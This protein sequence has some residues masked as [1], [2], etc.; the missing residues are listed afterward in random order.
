MNSRVPMPGGPT[1][2]RLAPAP[3]VRRDATAIAFCL[4]CAIALAPDALADTAAVPPRASAAGT[5]ALQESGSLRLTS[6]HEFTLNE[7]GRAS[8]TIKGAIYVHLRIVSTSRVSAE[9][10]IYPSHGSVTGYATASYHR[11]GPTANFQGTIA[12]VRGSGPYARAHGAGLS[13]SGTITRSDDAIT[14]RVSGRVSV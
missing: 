11:G 12:I 6:K 5:I 9:V 8:G 2:R 10:N 3:R 7:R 14:V 1:R 13:F 4:G